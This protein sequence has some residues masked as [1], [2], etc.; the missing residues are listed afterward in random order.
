MYPH[1]AHTVTIRMITIIK[2]DLVKANTKYSQSIKS[3][4]KDH[5][6]ISVAD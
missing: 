3:N 1:C 4:N 5:G 6:I 2:Y